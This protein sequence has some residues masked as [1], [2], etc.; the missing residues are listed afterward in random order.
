ME[1]HY[2]ITH[3]QTIKIHLHRTYYTQTFYHFVCVS[4]CNSLQKYVLRLKDME[5]LRGTNQQRKISIF[6]HTLI[7]NLYIIIFSK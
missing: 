1:I 7:H 3:Y 5:S 4:F 6:I 2:S